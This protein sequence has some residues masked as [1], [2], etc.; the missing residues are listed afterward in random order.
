VID[1]IKKKLDVRSI[2]KGRSN[3]YK[4]V[5]D[6]PDGKAVLADIRRQ[7]PIS[8]LHGAGLNA[9]R[10]MATAGKQELFSHI[11]GYLQLDDAAL[12]VILKENPLEDI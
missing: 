3:L 1:K 11:L 5:F 8:A 6:T 7:V 2:F 12:D 9:N 10:I 4:R